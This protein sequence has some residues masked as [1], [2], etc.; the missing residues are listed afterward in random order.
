MSPYKKALAFFVPFGIGL[1]FSSSASALVSPASQKILILGDSQSTTKDSPGGELEKR[2]ERAGANVLRIAVGGKTASFY[3]H[4]EE[5][6][7]LLQK[8]LAFGPSIVLI[9]LG[10]N[11]A[12][13]IAAGQKEAGM[14]KNLRALA[15][16]CAK[17]GATVFLLGPPSLDSSLEWKGVKGSAVLPH[18]VDSLRKEFGAQLVDLVPLTDPVKGR[19][20]VH[21]TG[22]GAEALADKLFTALTGKA[23]LPG[24]SKVDKVMSWAPF[25]LKSSA[26]H[27]TIP[28]ELIAAT[29]DLESGGD[30]TLVSKVGAMGLMQLMPGTAEMFKVKEPFDPEQNIEGGVKTLS[31]L[32]KRYHDSDHK[33]EKV[34]AAYNWGWGNVDKSEDAYQRRADYYDYI[35][36]RVPLYKERFAAL[37]LVSAAEQA[38][39]DFERALTM[40][41]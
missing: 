12:A 11:E 2:L 41:A 28:P 4:T 3:L 9:F 1:F 40:E 33:W 31:F 32:E 29:M 6:K 39:T 34:L 35:L 10:T 7:A 24:G 38:R 21:F 37:S 18:F 15:D 5:G 17:T 23:P 27:P 19:S 22:K 8:G 16:Q 20:G 26:K 14:V 36:P 25:I 13:N 30:P